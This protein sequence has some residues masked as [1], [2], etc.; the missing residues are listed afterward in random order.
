MEAA[1]RRKKNAIGLTPP[2]MGV[3]LL[4]CA[5]CFVLAVEPFPTM[6]SGVLAWGPVQSR[7]GFVVA[8]EFRKKKTFL[9]Y[10][11]RHQNDYGEVLRIS[12]GHY[13]LYQVGR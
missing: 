2:G 7:V 6:T 12:L 5:L 13:L 9:L 4:L 3:V 11:T 8:R 1:I 10:Q